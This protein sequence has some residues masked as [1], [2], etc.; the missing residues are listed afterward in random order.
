VRL[1]RGETASGAAQQFNEALVTVMQRVI[2]RTEALRKASKTTEI[3]EAAS[4]DE[5][6]LRGLQLAVTGH[7]LN[8]GIDRLKSFFVH[9]RRRHGDVPSMKQVEAATIDDLKRA[10]DAE[11][12]EGDQLSIGHTFA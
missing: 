8:T 4:S 1:G 12:P 7:A 9:A 10:L 3:N 6:A 11:V 2:T 5:E